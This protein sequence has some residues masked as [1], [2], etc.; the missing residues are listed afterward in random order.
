LRAFEW[1]ENLMRS[2]SAEWCHQSHWYGERDC[3]DLNALIF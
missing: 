3:I 1:T 2:W